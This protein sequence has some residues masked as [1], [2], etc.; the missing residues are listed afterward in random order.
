MT[1]Q[2]KGNVQ[3][4]CIYQCRPQS[5]EPWY[6]VYEEINADE[7]DDYENTKDIVRGFVGTLEPKQYGDPSIKSARKHDFDEAT[8]QSTLNALSTYH[9]DDGNSVENAKRDDGS[10]EESKV[11]ESEGD[12]ADEE[13]FADVSDPLVERYVEAS[14]SV[15][16]FLLFV[17]YRWE[18]D[19]YES[20]NRLMIVQLPLREDVF[21][22]EEEEADDDEG[23]EE[24]FSHLQDAF[25][26][27]LKKSV[28]YPYQEI[29]ELEDDSSEEVTDE[30]DGTSEADNSDED[31]LGVAYLFQGN[32]QAKYWYKFLN[33]RKEQHKDEILANQRVEVIKQLEDD[34]TDVEDID[35]PFKEI[36]SLEDVD[37]DELSDDIEQY[38]ESGVVVEIGNLKIQG[39]TVGDVLG[40]DAI[41][42][43]ERE[44]T[45]EVFTVIRGQEP[46]FRPVGKGTYH[47]SGDGEDN[48]E[49][50][51][52]P[53]F[54]ELS[55][56][57]DLS[58][59]I[60]D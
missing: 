38:W 29:S 36:D 28:L 5:D 22:P 60:N 51:E 43:Y 48:G 6:E 45:D 1:N 18:S 11:V 52:I 4:V 44:E 24:L 49:A 39:L 32:G 37:F 21:I 46:S 26:N 57:K 33:L 3:H 9:L 19:R 34:E 20:E 35:D 10:E 7:L 14:N 25:D 15:D 42:F 56:Y 23:A 55:E 2:Q 54:P 30:P 8:T 50:I 13:A 27:N 58:Q 53:I 47:Q 40:Q 31:R 17:E 41:E 59:L 12:D 16:C